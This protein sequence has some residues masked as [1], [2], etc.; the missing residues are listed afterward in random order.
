[1]KELNRQKLAE[2]I[3][4]RLY[5]DVSS[6]RVGGTA[7]VVKQHGE[8]V[9]EGFFG[10]SK[11]GGGVSPSKD[12][13]FRLASMT[14]PITG[15]AAM[16][17]MDRGL[18]SVDDNVDKYLPEFSEMSI[19]DLDN[20]KN[21]INVRPA[22]KKIKI[23]NLLTHTSGIGSDNLGNV[24]IERMTKGD[25]ANLK[26]VTEYFSKEPL[27]FEPESREAYSPTAALDVMARIVELVSDMPY[28]EFLEKEIFS[29]LNMRNTT[30]HPTDEQWDRMIYMHNLADG[31]NDEVNMGR[32]IFGDFPLTYFCGGAG[33]ASTLE[34][35]SIFAEMLRRKGEYNGIRILSEKVVKEMGTPQ[36]SESIMPY[37]IRWSYGV[38]V[39]DCESYKWLPKGAFGWSGAYGT[40]FWVDP[41]NDITA[42]YLKNSFYDGGSGAVTASNFEQDVFN[43]LED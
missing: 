21:V 29:K 16:I 2:N 8:T 19:A 30:F 7:I 28:D 35:Y 33:L 24:Q 1:M 25:K 18:I 32:Y 37:G 31:K 36:V 27:A 15:A 41:V 26:N 17:L 43:S 22:N 34:D 4:K 20:N 12:T 13:L 42:V 5:E 11:L 39:I 23:F 3:E 10:E 14:K 9:Y 40:H 38:R 6:C